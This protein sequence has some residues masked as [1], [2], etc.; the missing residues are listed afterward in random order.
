M[1]QNLSD[2]KLKNISNLQIGLNLMRKE[3]KPYD[4][5]QHPYKLV[6]L[7]SFCRTG[8]LVEHSLGKF[9]SDKT[10]ANRYLTRQGDVLVRLRTPNL[11]ICIEDE[12]HEG[13]LISAL[14]V[15]ITPHENI[16]ARYLTNY[17]NSAFMQKK[18]SRKIESVTIP[19][20]NVRELENLTIIAP[21]ADKQQTLNKIVEQSQKEIALLEQLASLKKQLNN[22]YF[23]QFINN[24]IKQ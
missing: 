7:K 16:N 24:E 8:K 17:I 13:L 23:N 5:K 15:K 10:I 21:P 3:G 1:L 6:M 9:I 18:I 11:A 4:E 19:M 22:A 2:A 20:L 12:K 14:M